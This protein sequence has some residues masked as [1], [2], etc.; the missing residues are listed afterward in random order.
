[1]EGD[2]LLQMAGYLLLSGGGG[3]VLYVLGATPAV[4][5]PALGERGRR[6]RLALE[7]GGLFP[8]LEPLIRKVSGWIAR[9]ELT[10]QRAQL[11]PLLR[12]SGYALGAT[13]DELIAMMLMSA[14]AAGSFS[15]L[16]A[17]LSKASLLS[18]FALSLGSASGSPIS[19]SRRR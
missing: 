17:T 12:S 2:R 1:M 9:F 19:S 6:R 4:V 14:V 5:A 11:E 8:T 16:I 15:L 7:D 18:W 10:R 13:P 3:T